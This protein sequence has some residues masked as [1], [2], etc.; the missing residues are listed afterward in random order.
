MSYKL[1]KAAL[2]LE[3]LPTTQKIVLIALA[4]YANDET[5]ECWPAQETIAGLCG[6]SRKTVNQSVK[7]LTDKGLV[8][9]HGWHGKTP[10]YRLNLLPTVTPVTESYTN[11]LPTVTPPVTQG[12]TKVLPTVTQIDNIN[13]EENKES[14]KQASIVESNI[15]STPTPPQ[16]EKTMTTPQVTQSQA[17]PAAAACID[18]KFSLKEIALAALAKLKAEGID[19]GRAKQMLSAVSGEFKAEAKTLRDGGY[20]GISNPKAYLTA[21]LVGMAKNGPK[22]A[23]PQAE[24]PTR[25]EE[26]FEL[27]KKEWAELYPEVA[28]RFKTFEIYDLHPSTGN[29]LRAKEE[30]AWKSVKGSRVA[31]VRSTLEGT[32]FERVQAWRQEELKEVAAAL[33]H[34]TSKLAQLRFVPKSFYSPRKTVEDEIAELAEREKKCRAKLTRLSACATRPNAA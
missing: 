10:N 2:H 3:G 23:T 24:E 1:A 8:K 28:E 32:V 16:T 11:L 6:M 7:A 26:I 5:G 12:Y 14:N 21:K 13:R 17:T 33:E 30:S 31:Y 9:Q 34:V 27:L 18:A 15:I 25:L 19:D 22:Q 20:A 29:K 4:D